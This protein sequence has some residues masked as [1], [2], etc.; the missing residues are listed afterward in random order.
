MPTAHA[1]R[2]AVLR[3]AADFRKRDLEPLGLYFVRMIEAR[4]REED[5]PTDALGEL[6][7]ASVGVARTASRSVLGF[8][9]EMAFACRY[10]VEAAGGLDSTDV[11][12]LNERLVRTLHNR[13]GYDD[14]LELVARRIGAE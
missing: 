13:D 1:R 10:Q 3:V 2:D 12:A 11:R 14:P 6:D 8:M 7:P 4:L 5:L 9:N